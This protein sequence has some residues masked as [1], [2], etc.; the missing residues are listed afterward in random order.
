MKFTFYF[1][2]SLIKVQL[3]CP[4]TYFGLGL[5][6]DSVADFSQEKVCCQKRCCWPYRHNEV[7]QGSWLSGTEDGRTVF[8]SF[9]FQF[10][11]LHGFLPSLLTAI[12]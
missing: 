2:V 6:V 7:F 12:F 4:L 11:R 5:F 9:L 10:L 8:F 1:R 3:G